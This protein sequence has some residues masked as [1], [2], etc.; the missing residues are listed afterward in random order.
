MKNKI[1]FSISKDVLMSAAMTVN[2]DLE[3]TDKEILQVTNVMNDRICEFL[4]YCIR[5][6]KRSN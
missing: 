2:E 5:Q 4:A 1:I 3:L 6:I